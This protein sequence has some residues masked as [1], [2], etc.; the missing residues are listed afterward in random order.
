MRSIEHWIDGVRT[1]GGPTLPV[2]DP[3]TGRPVGEVALG[4]RAE[5]DAA[6]SAAARA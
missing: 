6:V 3:A 4:R 1:G 5:V 2:E